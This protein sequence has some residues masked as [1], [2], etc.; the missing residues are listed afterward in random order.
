MLLITPSRVI[1]VAQ[2]MDRAGCAVILLCD[3]QAGRMNTS[4]IK[5]SRTFSLLFRLV[6]A[7]NVSLDEKKDA[8][9]RPSA[10]E[11]KRVFSCYKESETVRR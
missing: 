7:T 6:K 5:S 9:A 11:K 4:D 3:W 8:V 2:S 1:P 10:D